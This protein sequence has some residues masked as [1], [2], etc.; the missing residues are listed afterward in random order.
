MGVSSG[1]YLFQDPLRLYW[2]EQAAEQEAQA[3][4]GS[5]YG[6]KGAEAPSFAEGVEG[7]SQAKE[8]P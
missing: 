1:V 8:Q 2:Q 4:Q 6:R 3:E 5:L 7:Q